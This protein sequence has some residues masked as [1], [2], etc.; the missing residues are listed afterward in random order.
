M[1]KN[2]KIV[3]EGV[4]RRNSKGFGF[5]KVE[6][7]EE[8]YHISEKNMK[9]AL[10]GDTVQIKVIEK[11]NNLDLQDEAKII[12][13]ISHKKDTVVGTTWGIN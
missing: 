4:L 6:G 9:N 13:I 10:D 12:K 11:S 7:K 1:K 2:K 5:V 8:E 3:I